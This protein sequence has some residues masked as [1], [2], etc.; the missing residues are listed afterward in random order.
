[1]K[2]TEEHERIVEAV[3]ENKA[4]IGKLD[5]WLGEL[6]QTVAIL[7]W[8]DTGIVMPKLRS[9]YDHISG[10]L[11]VAMHTVQQAQYHRLSIGLFSSLK[12]FDLFEDLQSL[13]RSYGFKL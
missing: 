13:A 12:L 1:M 8:L 9:M 4:N 11:E 10:A 5:Q 7:P 3:A 2:I 6:N